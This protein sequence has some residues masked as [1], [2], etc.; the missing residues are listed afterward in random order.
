MT[1]LIRD[2]VEESVDPG[3]VAGAGKS[4]TGQTVEQRE[5][6]ISDDRHD[7]DT[8]DVQAKASTDDSQVSQLELGEE[9]EPATGTTEDPWIPALALMAFGLAILGQLYLTKVDSLN[10][11]AW[12]HVGALLCFLVLIWRGQ[13][14]ARY[15]ESSIAL[16]RRTRSK[17]EAHSTESALIVLAFLVDLMAVRL[18]RA[19]PRESSRWDAFGLWVVAIVLFLVATL[20]PDWARF[21][22]RIRSWRRWL[23]CHRIEVAS[24][25]ALTLLAFGLRFVALGSI[26]DVIDSD[27]ADLGLLALQALRGEMKDMFGTFKS[28]GTMYVFFLAVPLWI[29]DATPLGLRFM[30]ALVGS[31]SIP[32]LFLLGR[33]LFGA[34]IGLIAA[35][36]LAVSHYHIHFSRI[37]PGEVWDPFLA[38][39]VLY[40]LYRGLEG[41]STNMLILSGVALGLAQYMFVGARLIAMVA[42]AYL[43]LL[44]ILQR[45][46]VTDNIG[47]LV[48]FALAALLVSGPMIRWA[49]D[50]TADYMARVNQAGLIQTGWLARE[51]ERTGRSKLWVL[52]DQVRRAFLVFNYYPVKSFYDATMPVLDFLSAGVFV[53]G[54]AYSLLRTLDQRY[55]LL[56]LWFWFGVIIGGALVLNTEISGYRILVVFPAVVLYVAVGVSKLLDLSVRGLEHQRRVTLLLITM[57]LV[58]VAFLNLRFYFFEYARECRYTDPN[59]ATAAMIGEYLGKVGPAYDGYFVGPPG[60]NMAWAY[61]NLPFLSGGR[62][63]QEIAQPSELDQLVSSSSTPKVFFV[64]SQSSRLLRVLHDRYP[65]GTETELRRCGRLMVTAYQVN[66][67]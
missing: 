32:V 48:F 28:Y 4:L 36:V 21:L 12:A 54:V 31:M 46:L 24:F 5:R 38:I 37:I 3:A 20:D 19:A 66:S 27:G 17:L 62:A 25:V 63:V 2:D 6:E 64:H 61:R 39:L 18:L 14:S 26:P 45:R 1:D 15:S 60:T 49:I 42:I 65:R 33:R 43:G 56:N 41:G 16:L 8:R 52:A 35:A 23:V 59:T 29:F 40:F 53:L 7:S 34:R 44:F 57:F 67:P 55:A 10:D 58:F 30:P 50:H 9:E 11:A 22:S 13:L 47:G 51:A